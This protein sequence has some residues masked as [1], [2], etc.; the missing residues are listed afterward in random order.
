MSS[1]LVLSSIVPFRSFIAAFKKNISTMPLHRLD[2]VG[3]SMR[4]LWEDCPF[5]YTDSEANE[6][7]E[8][9]LETVWSSDYEADCHLARLRAR[10]EATEDICREILGNRI[11]E[12][13]FEALVKRVG[14][15]E[16]CRIRRRRMDHLWE[17][18]EDDCPIQRAE[19]RAEFVAD[20]RMSGTP[21]DWD[22]YSTL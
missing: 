10:V 13:L 7:H 17:M 14:L 21:I 15:D 5:V 19:R 16:A 4:V 22:T 12:L 2:R 20:S 3:V 9:I 6:E 8:R 18:E 1:A 11:D